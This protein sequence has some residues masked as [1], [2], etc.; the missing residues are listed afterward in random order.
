MAEVPQRT[1][2]GLHLF[3]SLIKDGCEWHGDIFSPKWSEVLYLPSGKLDN[4][5]RTLAMYEEGVDYKRDDMSI[6][7]A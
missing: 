4:V 7:I 5:D 2:N 6:W 3:K 1:L